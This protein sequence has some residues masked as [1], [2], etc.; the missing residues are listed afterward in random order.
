MPVTHTRSTHKRKSSFGST[1]AIVAAVHVFMGAVI[2]W[3]TTT[4]TGQKM[5]KEYKIKFYQPPK[6]EEPKKEA[7]KEE[8]PPP[9]PKKEEAKEEVPKAPLS[10]REE[11][12]QAQQ[13]V[14]LGGS[15]GDPFSGGPGKA[16]DAHQA[17]YLAVTA[18]IRSHFHE[19]DNLAAEE[20]GPTKMEI[21]VDD[22]G[23]VT[24][25]RLTG[26]SGNKDLDRAALEAVKSVGRVNA[27]RP[28]TLDRTL[29]VR[30]IPP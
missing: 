9:P 2:L 4:E 25:Y 15:G 24:K 12:P 16:I 30:F 5:Y 18:A 23:Y 22:S 29:F 14:S 26:S 20:Y 17:Y 19:P 11:T 3:V 1:L 27:Q 28:K 6:K 8:P 10:R 21:T 7:K 13:E